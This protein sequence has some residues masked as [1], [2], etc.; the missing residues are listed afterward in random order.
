MLGDDGI[1]LSE[2]KRLNRAF[3]KATTRHRDAVVS[4]ILLMWEDGLANMAIAQMIEVER[5]IIGA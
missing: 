3:K 1:S 5:S 2:H 4:K